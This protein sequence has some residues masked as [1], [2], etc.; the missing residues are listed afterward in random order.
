[1]AIF[2]GRRMSECRD[3]FSI[4]RDFV[5]WP[6]KEAELAFR[7]DRILCPSLGESHSSDLK[8]AP[9][10]LFGM[11]GSSPVFIRSLYLI[12]KFAASDAP[13]LIGG[14]TGTGKEVAARAVH[15]LSKRKEFPFIP[16]NCGAL[17]DQLIENELFGHDTGAYTDAKHSQPGVIDRAQK[18]T[19]FLDEIGNLTGRGQCA[20]LRFLETLEYRRLGSRELRR[21]DVRIIAAT[22]ADLE[23]IVADGHFRSDLL[24]RLNILSIEMPPL[25][26]RRGDT[27]EIA[28]HILKNL[29]RR[30]GKGPVRFTR[31]SLEWMERYKWPGN[32]REMENLVHR[33]FL[34]SD[35]LLLDLRRADCSGDA[36]G[37][38]DGCR[39]A[40][41]A[42]F[43]QAKA[44]VIEE[45][46]RDYLTE[47]LRST[48]GN[49]SQAARIA[50]KERRALGKLLKKHGINRHAFLDPS[51]LET[52]LKM[53][54][55]G[56]P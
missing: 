18:G 11:V 5:V 41:I 49:V 56:L 34:L 14:E 3:L 45:F 39:R 19:L 47:L 50:G 6:C 53:T 28:H 20:I 38:D 7:L 46:E 42:G 15:Y 4:V 29:R 33:A 44:H 26:D 52:G 17:P 1:M 40:R 13:L 22:N 24:F 21:A 30:Y 2:C 43:Q 55:P 9:R 31:D 8:T 36:A 32:I 51:T 10:L 25:R 27:R 37:T 35:G 54:Q 48:A 16:V 23:T 12:H